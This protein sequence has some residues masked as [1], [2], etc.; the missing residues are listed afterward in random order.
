MTSKYGFGLMVIAIMS[1]YALHAMMKCV[2]HFL[3]FPCLLATAFPDT[4][5][6]SYTVTTDM[7]IRSWRPAN[8]LT[9][10]K[11]HPQGGAF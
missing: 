9:F 4:N 1:F 7:L 5:A 2:K 11:P 10:S 6:H 8:S 3:L